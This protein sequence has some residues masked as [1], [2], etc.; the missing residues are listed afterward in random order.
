MDAA[1]EYKGDDC[2][3]L[4]ANYLNSVEAAVEIYAEDL[5]GAADNFEVD[6]LGRSFFRTAIH[7]GLA[8]GAIWLVPAVWAICL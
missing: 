3:V 8:A 2:V 7:C 1:T 5:A 4:P 6:G